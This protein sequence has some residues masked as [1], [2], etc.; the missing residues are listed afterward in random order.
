MRTVNVFPT[1]SRWREAV[2]LGRTGGPARA[3]ARQAALTHSY[4]VDEPTA[5][6]VVGILPGEPLA[7]GSG[8]APGLAVGGG[9]GGCHF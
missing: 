1:M 2:A 7:S 9:P 8:L 3:R 5:F 4:S 6:W